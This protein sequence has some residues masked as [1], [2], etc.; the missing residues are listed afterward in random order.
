MREGERGLDAQQQQ[1]V[2][3]LDGPLLVVAGPG[4]GKTRV[5]TH[6]AG[7]L[8]ERDGDPSRQ[9]VVTFTNKAA[10][11]LRERLQAI[12]Q[13]EL[14]GMWV[15]TFHAACARVLRIDGHHVG[16]PERFT[17][18]GADDAR[19]VAKQTV[20]ARSA[21]GSADRELVQRLLRVV[22]R[23]KNRLQDVDALHTATDPGER[24]LAWLAGDYQRRLRDSG[25][26]DFDDLLFEAVRLLEEHP[27]V[28]ERWQR[29][30]THVS[31]DEFQ[32][33]NHAQYRLLQLLA[34]EHRNL[35]AVGDLDQSIYAWRSAD[36]TLMASFTR[37]WP[38]ARVVV[39]DRNYRSTSQIVTAARMVIGE[40]PAAWRPGLVAD[41]GEGDAVRVL[42]CADEEDE[43]R[44]VADH[45]VECDHHEDDHAV[46]FR[47]NAQSNLVERGLAAVGVPCRV[48]GTQRF[49][50]R[51]EV[52]DAVAWLRA[53]VSD[54]DDPAF[55][56]AVAS[57]RSGVGPKT[58]DAVRGRSERDRTGV[59]VAARDLAGE[60]G[61][62]GK[63]LRRWLDALD[64]V[65]AAT[66]PS[67][68]L[69]VVYDE[70]G[71]YRWYRERRDERAAE[72]E[73]N[74][75]ELRRDVASLER[76]GART[77]EEVLEVLALRGSADEDDER[78]VTLATVHAAKG[79]EFACVHVVGVE[80]G[81]F[82]HTLS[83]G[84]GG[85]EEERRLLFVA[86]TRARDR[87]TLTRAARRWARGGREP[88]AASPFLT[89]VVRA[90]EVQSQRSA[91]LRT[92][93]SPRPQPTLVPSP[94]APSAPTARGGAGP[95]VKAEDLHADAVVDH[96]VHGRGVVVR[97][98]G[99]RAVVRFRDRERV[100]GLR[101]APM[102]LVGDGGEAL[103][104]EPAAQRRGE[105]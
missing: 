95:R 27:A 53:A 69:E 50:E 18:A 61:R 7:R 77:L 93:P 38:D 76:D 81:L 5:L 74:L 44:S 87:L 25:L 31:V 97:V 78:G 102:R 84:D 54:H 104:S 90:E 103:G 41:R 36:P 62:G 46:L 100:M 4:S 80:D 98:D 8:A 72:R 68:A 23:A 39:L 79:R 96:D 65:R 34:G 9:L 1:A 71:L 21:D 43:A 92:P 86:M 99:D 2:D 49:Y 66:S 11:E 55:A 35:M 85:E 83:G 16:T 22:S 64:R 47:T 37:D 30:F 59:V 24:D 63:A 26:L 10:G 15:C 33:T 73:E 12:V 70:V 57:P 82:P 29:R 75:D 6:R 28:R 60:G 52:A 101:F 88:R 17:V 42:V 14:E 94:P 40:N 89:P 56:R 32:D 45:V 48:V 91:S 13:R 3:T 105:P 67:A 58:V 19:A 20:A 51:A